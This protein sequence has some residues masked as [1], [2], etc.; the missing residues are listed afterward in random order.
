[1]KGFIAYMKAM[2][3]FGIPTDQIATMVQ[4]NPAQLLAC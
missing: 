4:K 2:M 1:V 3:T